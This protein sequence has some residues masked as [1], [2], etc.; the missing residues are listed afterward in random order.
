MKEGVQHLDYVGTGC[1][2]EYLDKDGQKDH[3]PEA[4]EFSLTTLDDAIMIGF[5]VLIKDVSH[6]T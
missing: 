1:L 2:N 6:R 3:F 4:L 5:C